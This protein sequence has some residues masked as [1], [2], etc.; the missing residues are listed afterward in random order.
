MNQLYGKDLICTQDWSLDDLKQVID[1]AIQMKLE[2]N[3]PK[4]RKSLEY[5][6][7]LMLFYSP[8]VRTHLSFSTA[9]TELGGHAQYMV[10]TMGRFKSTSSAGESIEDAAQVMAGYMAGIGIRTM[11]SS[12]ASYGEGNALIREYAKWSPVPVINMADD[13]FHPCQ[14]LSDIM[15][16]SEWFGGTQTG[17]YAN[18]KKKNLLL[19]WGHGSLARSWNSPQETLLLASRFGLNITIAR[20]DGY[21]LD[22]NVYRE[23]ERNCEQTKTHFN[24]VDNPEAGYE[25]ANIVYSRHWVSPDAYKGGQFQKQKEIEKALTYSKWI[26]TDQKMSK[27]DNSI[28][29]HPMPIDRGY[30]VEDAVASG[31]NSVIYTVAHNRLHIQK[32]ILSLIMGNSEK[33][34][35]EERSAGESR[36]N[37]FAVMDT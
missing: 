37:A 18:L 6:N 8:S 32:A 14:A 28:F 22:P 34:N 36:E 20:P 24:I 7:F 30:E 4:W 11:E 29:T 26:T 13:M 15:G 23:I 3:N 19:T 31:P 10:P 17:N 35:L 16:W 2:R 9:A 25:N 5:K 27:T 1:L 33:N 21:D 12:I